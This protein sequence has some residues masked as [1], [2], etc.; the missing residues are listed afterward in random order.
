MKT[1]KLLVLFAVGTLVLCG[2]NKKTPVQ[3]AFNEVQQ[4]IVAVK[5]SLPAECQTEVV[6]TKLDAIETK[7]QI[8]ENACETQINNIQTKYE[9][10]LWVL[11]A[12][13]LVFFVKFF[14]KR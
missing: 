1:T 7:R 10:V 6:M 4:S 3:T 2:C 14:I 9:R 12:V 11:F 13:F 8:A 5:D